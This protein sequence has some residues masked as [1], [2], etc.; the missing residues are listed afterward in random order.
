MSTSNLK[1]PREQNWSL[2]NLFFELI[3]LVDKVDK[4]KK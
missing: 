4:I 2:E 1:W 3:F